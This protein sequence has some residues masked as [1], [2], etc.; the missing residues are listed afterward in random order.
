[1]YNL[2]WIPI[3]VAAAAVQVGRTAIQKD[4]KS[5]MDTEA[6]TWARYGL[7]LPFVLTYFLLI[8]WLHDFDLPVMNYKFLFYCLLGGVAQIIGTMLMITM[9]SYRSF[10]VA[11]TF[12]KTSTIQI[13]IIGYLF[14][15]E[16]L[17]LY[18]WIAVL[19]G[20]IGVMCLS[21]LRRNINERSMLI[22]MLSGT[23]IAISALCIRQACLA[24]N[25]DTPFFDA[26]ITLMV[27]VTIQTILLGI[28]MFAKK[29]RAFTQY[30][31]NLGKSLLIGFTSCVGSM[32]WYTAFALAP[33]AYVRSVGQ[34]EI[35]FSLAVTSHIFKEHISKFDLAGILLILISVIL[36]TVSSL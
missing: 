31:R 3:S 17:N 18:G 1:M 19:I 24:L 9:F 13:A 4:L 36:L 35:I 11:I 12:S 22:G 10:A 2:L 7:A 33:A 27:M 25:S 5:N 21:H 23:G 20:S 29:N 30:K 14:F 34:V 32:G 26:A 6:I 28:Y 16:L 15:A 8:A